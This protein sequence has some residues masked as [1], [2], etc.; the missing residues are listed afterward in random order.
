MSILNFEIID[1]GFS[2]KDPR[3]L[4]G[5]SSEEI[6]TIERE[7]YF[8]RLTFLNLDDSMI[9]VHLRVF[10]HLK[11]LFTRFLELRDW[12]SHHNVGSYSG[13]DKEPISSTFE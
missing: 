6:E 3:A 9:D 1:Y 2:F 5:Q 8:P 4:R 13:S 10:S 7:T 11:F 12:Y